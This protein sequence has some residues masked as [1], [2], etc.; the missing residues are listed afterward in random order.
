MSSQ[1]K[2]CLSNEFKNIPFDYFYTSILLD[3]T[4]GQHHIMLME[5]ML[6]NAELR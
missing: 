3:K 1:L 4:L 2:K 6:Y 5:Q